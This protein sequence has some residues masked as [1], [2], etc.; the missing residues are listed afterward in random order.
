MIELTEKRLT[1]KD[2]IC[3]SED[4]LRE[5]VHFKD[6]T[7]WISYWDVPSAIGMDLE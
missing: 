7:P 2:G 6:P 1:G 5:G 4:R 3:R